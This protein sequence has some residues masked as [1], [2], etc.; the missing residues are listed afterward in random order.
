[1][2][3]KSKGKTARASFKKQE[4]P[5]PPNWPPLKPL[6]PASDL[7]METLLKD[8]IVVIRKFFTSSLCK[9][10]VSFL[11]SLPLVTTPG[12]P[13]K[14]DALRVNDRF[15][16]NDPSFAEE[17]WATAGLQNLVT[18]TDAGNGLTKPDFTQ[19]WGGEVCGL[20]PRI[21]IYRYTRGQFFDQHCT[22]LSY[23]VFVKMTSMSGPLLWIAS[24]K[25]LLNDTVNAIMLFVHFILI[26]MICY[27]LLRNLADEEGGEFPDRRDKILFVAGFIS[28]TTVAKGCYLAYL[29]LHALLMST[30]ILLALHTLGRVLN[31]IPIPAI[32]LNH[33]QRQRLL[34]GFRMR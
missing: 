3:A 4:S 1:M 32:F 27:R 25:E 21:R 16:V 12:Q 23:E 18:G 5:P 14:G 13:R 22:T 2:P 24:H 10:Y 11:S 33:L 17:L 31:A 8:Q 30:I 28:C 7:T 29:V 9:N 6:V 34:R 26:L 15:Q 19:F 20:N